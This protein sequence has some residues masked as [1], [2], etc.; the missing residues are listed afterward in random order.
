MSDLHHLAMPVELQAIVQTPRLL[1]GESRREYETIRRMLIDDIR[2]ET[3]IEWLWTIFL[4]DL[5]WEILRYRSL[6]QTT[7]EAFRL[8]AV[9]VALQRADG[10]GIPPDATIAVQQ[11]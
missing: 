11:Q 6:K 2:P 8:T 9:E 1:P 4:V 3:H 5:S 7:L 10:Y